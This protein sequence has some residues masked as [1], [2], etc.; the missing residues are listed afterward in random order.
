MVRWT[1]ATQQVRF[2]VVLFL[3]NHFCKRRIDYL[4]CMIG[5]LCSMLLSTIVIALL[6]YIGPKNCVRVAIFLFLISISYI[7]DLFFMSLNYTYSLMDQTLK[8]SF[9]SNYYIWA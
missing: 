2:R 6:I 4:F 8:V 9:T 1:L 5:L 7:I 3:A